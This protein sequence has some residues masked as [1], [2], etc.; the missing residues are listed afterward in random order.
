MLADSKARRGT[1]E[2]HGGKRGTRRGT[3][4]VVTLPE[5]GVS[6]NTGQGRML[7]GPSKGNFFFFFSYEATSP[8]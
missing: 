2:G 7:G 6:W 5:R 3:Q 8:S 4:P 1:S